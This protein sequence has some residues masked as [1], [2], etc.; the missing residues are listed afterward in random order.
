[1][2]L[3]NA[4]IFCLTS[5]FIYLEILIVYSSTYYVAGTVVGGHCP[6]GIYSWGEDKDVDKY[7][8][9]SGCYIVGL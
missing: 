1:M 9:Y 8:K 2:S 5:V 6:L 4:E 3:H 7:D